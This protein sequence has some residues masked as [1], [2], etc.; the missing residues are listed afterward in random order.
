MRQLTSEERALLI[1]KTRKNVKKSNQ[2]I[3]RAERANLTRTQP[4]DSV[5]KLTRRAGKLTRQ[6]SKIAKNTRFPTKFDHLNDDDLVKFSQLVETAI[7]YGEKGL[8]VG[9]FNKMRKE[10]DNF[11]PTKARPSSLYIDEGYEKV[12]N[13]L[14]PHA[15][16]DANLAVMASN[17]IDSF[18]WR[19][20][21][22]YGIASSNVQQM[23]EKLKELSVKGSSH[24]DL[25]PTEINNLLKKNT[26]QYLLDH[27]ETEV[28]NERL[29]QIMYNTLEDVSRYQYDRSTGEF[30]KP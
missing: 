22:K 24:N 10:F 17:A 21:N 23:N 30:I 28:N 3:V 14:D 7:T 13:F 29:T 5:D 6:T 12:L 9:A 15:E 19:I 1:E 20:Q 8:N 27:R 4:F 25:T 16:D 26:I 2:R 11:K 18:T